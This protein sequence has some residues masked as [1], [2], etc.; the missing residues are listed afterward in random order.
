M[1]LAAAAFLLGS[2][3]AAL[4]AVA[5]ALLNVASVAPPLDDRADAAAPGVPLRLLL[6]N[7]ED[8]NARYGDVARLV[9]E[10]RPDV[11]GVTELD[12]SWAA[13]LQGRLPAYTHGLLVPEEGAYGAGVYSRLPLEAREERFPAGAG[14]ATLV[15]RLRPRGA[16]ELT[17]VVTHVHTLFAGSIHARHLEAL[18]AARPR[19]GRH[20]AVCGDFNTVPWSS[21]FRRFADAGLIDLYADSWPGHSWPTWSALLRVPIDNCLVDGV[22]VVD[23]R[24]GPD[25]G[26]DHYPLI[27]DL[28]VPRSP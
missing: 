5:A 15:A 25:I 20:V 24:H 12:R 28:A 16:E 9:R 19:L 8:G 7:V 3:R 4:A 21:A 1:P 14:P 17:F 11:I 2:R 10:V 13:E 27:V 18:A 22:S 26:S 6:I 23:H